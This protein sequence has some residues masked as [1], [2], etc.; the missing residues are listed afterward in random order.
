MDLCGEE[1][2]EQRRHAMDLCRDERLEQCR[3]A[4]AL[5]WEGF[6]S[7]DLVDATAVATLPTLGQPPQPASHAPP[8]RHG[9]EWE[10]K[11]EAVR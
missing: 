4:M 6:T 7:L 9:P 1:R 2:L 3:H 5:R 8:R 10:G 11:G